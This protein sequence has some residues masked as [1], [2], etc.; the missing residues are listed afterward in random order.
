M[1][2]R[3]EL[4]WEGHGRLT[5]TRPHGCGLEL[6]GLPEGTGGPRA[7]GRQRN[8]ETQGCELVPFGPWWPLLP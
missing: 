4:S 1:L 6:Q 3:M 7:H 8:L 5:R 2:T